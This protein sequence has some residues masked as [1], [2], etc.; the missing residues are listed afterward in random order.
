M[1]GKLFLVLMV[2]K[3]PLKGIPA[4]MLKVALD[5]HLSLIKK[6]INLQLASGCF[7]GNLK[8]AEV[9]SIFKKNDDLDKENYSP[10]SVLFNVSKV[11]QRIIYRQIDSL[12][13]HKLSNL[14]TSF[15]K[16]H[17]TQNCL[18]LVLEIWK[19]MKDMYV[20]CS[21]AYERPLTQYT[22]I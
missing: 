11:F 8:P 3:P 21:W 6:I 9:S 20:L 7:P 1:N 17:S 5:I 18:M 15:R 16:K 12:M 13:Q 14:L 2:L 4:N 22:L 10:A 19:N